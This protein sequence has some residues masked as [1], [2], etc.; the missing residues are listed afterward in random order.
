MSYLWTVSNGANAGDFSAYGTF[1]QVRSKWGTSSLLANAGPTATSLSGLHACGISNN[2]TFGKPIGSYHEAEA[3]TMEF[4]A[5]W[6]NSFNG[7]ANTSYILMANIPGYNN[8]AGSAGDGAGGPGIGN[9]LL[10]INSTTAAW[11]VFEGSTKITIG[12]PTATQSPINQW[13]YYSISRS[14]GFYW[15]FINGALIAQT[16][17]VGGTAPDFS[18]FMFGGY[19]GVSPNIF[20]NGYFSEFLLT[21]DVNKYTAPYSVP[22][23]AYNAGTDP[24]ASKVV[25]YASF[26]GVLSGGTTFTDASPTFVYPSV[27]ATSRDLTS[28]ASEVLAQK[29][30]SDR[31]G[32]ASEVLARSTVSDRDGIVS[33][34]VAQ[35]TSQISQTFYQSRTPSITQDTSPTVVFDQTY[36]ETSDFI[37]QYDPNNVWKYGVPDGGQLETWNYAIQAEDVRHRTYPVGQ[38]FI[39]GTVSLNGVP[40]QGALIKIVNDSYTHD[41]FG[42]IPVVSDV[43]GNFVFHNI[44]G[45]DFEYTLRCTPPESYGLNDLVWDGVKA[46]SYAF[47]VTGGFTTDTVNNEVDSTALIV[48]GFGPFDI[49]LNSGLLPGGTTLAVVGNQIQVQGATTFFATSY[50][51]NATITAADGTSNAFDFQIVPVGTNSLGLVSMHEGVNMSFFERALSTWLDFEMPLPGVISTTNVNAFQ[52]TMADWASGFP[53]WIVDKG[54]EL[55]IIGGPYSTINA[56][57][58]DLLYDNGIASP[59][60]SSSVTGALRST[61]QVKFGTYSGNINGNASSPF[62]F[63]KG[64]NTNFQGD[65]SCSMWVLF[66]TLP[67]NTSQFAFIFCNDDNSGNRGFRFAVTSNSIGWTVRGANGVDYT[68]SGPQLPTGVWVHVFCGRHGQSLYLATGGTMNIANN[69]IPVGLPLNALAPN[70]VLV[71]GASN[72]LRTNTSW[73]YYM[74]DVVVCNGGCMYTANYTPPSTPFNPLISRY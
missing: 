19:G 51:F 31:D 15:F 20:G 53:Y 46:V 39:A 21:L 17:I 37:V 71:F 22:T 42:D 59:I 67:A 63:Y 41:S 74:D 33:E 36:V 58:P 60:I 2:S 72:G 43:N 3:F 52:G 47:H 34:V 25:I 61:T 18:T 55:P 38:Y 8:S 49:T 54:N 10:R 44:L 69:I 62:A 40:M 12:T 35:K 5:Y 65:F 28:I 23:A 30:V 7:S 9:W 16:P 24:N 13:N 73:T 32:L 29:T 1:T 48:G 45:T 50:V 4:W 14:G 26:D 6:A 56:A 27:S 11:N 68:V 66:P 70:N 64:A 57:R